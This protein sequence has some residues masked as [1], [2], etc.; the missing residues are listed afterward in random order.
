MKATNITIG[1]DEEQ[2]HV[3]NY[4]RCS[5]AVSFSTDDE[6][7]VDFFKLMLECGKPFSI[8]VDGKYLFVVARSIHGHHVE[9]A[10]ETSTQAKLALDVH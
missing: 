3:T 7:A 2:T 10:F 8:T 4:R 1:G 9:L 6:E 5:D